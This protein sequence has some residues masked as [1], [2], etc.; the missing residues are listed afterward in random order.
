MASFD[1]STALILMS[2]DG[3]NI[4]QRQSKPRI[5]TRY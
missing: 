5:N 2:T 4:L 1:I 3:N